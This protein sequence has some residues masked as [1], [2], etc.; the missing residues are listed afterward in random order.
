MDAAYGQ[1]KCPVP[2]CQN[3]V[4]VLVITHPDTPKERERAMCFDCA[5]K[6][7]RHAKQ[8]SGADV[9]ITTLD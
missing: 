5:R 2:L 8:Y 6:Y 7:K 3:R 1:E 9:L 4:T